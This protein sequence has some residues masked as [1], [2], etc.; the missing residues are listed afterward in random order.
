MIKIQRVEILTPGRGGY[1][2]LNVTGHAGFAPKGQDILCAAVSA[3]VSALERMVETG[4]GPGGVLQMGRVDRSCGSMVEVSAAPEHMAEVFGW[5]SLV[6]GALE[7][8]ARQYPDHIMMNG[9][10]AGKGA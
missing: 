10:T 4:S 2:R 3:L 6:V 1:W 5:F 7:E 8:L 9:Q